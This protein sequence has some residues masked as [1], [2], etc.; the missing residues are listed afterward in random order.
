MNDK[1]LDMVLEYL[2]ENV[3]I[4]TVE[5]LYE[6]LNEQLEELEFVDES[7]FIDKIKYTITKVIE[8]IKTFI[9]NILDKIITFLKNA[10]KKLLASKV[11]E[12]V[13]K[14]LNSEKLNEASNS[15]ETFRYYLHN[16][17][18]EVIDFENPLFANGATS[19]FEKLSNEEFLEKCLNENIKNL[20]DYLKKENCTLKAKFSY[21]DIIFKS[22]T[23]S[24]EWDKAAL[25]F[26]ALRKQLDHEN[27]EYRKASN[28]IEKSKDTKELEKS[29]QNNIDQTKIGIELAKELAKEFS[30]S[31][32]TA[33]DLL[34]GV[35]DFKIKK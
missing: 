4:D 20:D 22:E 3:E 35:L 31:A 13:Q 27:L 26:I 23:L 29:L 10:S 21:F 1:Q 7:K 30:K 5:F 16:N 11:K 34:Y 14:M 25:N 8:L 19:F 2:N 18:V 24:K 33:I 12:K 9:K 6:S 15:T 28:S 32:G 17:F